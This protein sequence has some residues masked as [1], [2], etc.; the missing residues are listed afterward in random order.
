MAVGASY[1]SSLA[2][3]SNRD[4]YT[5]T[6]SALE[7]ALGR[8]SMAVMGYHKPFRP[9]STPSAARFKLPGTEYGGFSVPLLLFISICGGPMPFIPYRQRHHMA[10]QTLEWPFW[11]EIAY[12]RQPY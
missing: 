7:S 10:K 11:L 9:D 8:N 2:A 6:S 1:S 12:L 5:N 3:L 4:L